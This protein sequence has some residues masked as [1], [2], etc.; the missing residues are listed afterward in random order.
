MNRFY[1]QQGHG[2][3][4]LNREFVEKNSEV[5]I[6]LS[7][8]NCK[9]EQIEKH[10]KE[11]H[12]RNA[13]VL[14][15]PQFY[16]PRTERENILN[17]PYWN[18][19]SFETVS[20]LQSGS[21]ELCSG[22]IRYQ[23][24]ELEVDEVILPGRYTNAVNEEWLE[25][26]YSIVNT[27]AS[28]NLDELVYTTLALGPDVIGQKQVFDRIVNEVIQ[29]PVDG[30]YIV[31]NTP[32]YLVND[33]IY[34]YNLLD[35]LLS[36]KLAGKKVLVGYANQQALIFA[37][38][39]VSGLATGNFRNVRKF[40]PETFDVPLEDKKPQRATWYYDGQTLSEYRIPAL[41][42]AYQRGLKGNF[43]PLSPYTKELLESSN[44]THIKWGEREAFRHYLTL[45]KQQW[46][47]VNKKP[48][49][50]RIQEVIKLLEEAEEKLNGLVE[51]AFRPGERS[52]IKCFEP[53]LNAITALNADRGYE[54][55]LLD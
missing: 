48:V 8:R 13:A 51:N 14:F 1:L 6:I 21:R 10:A 39:G 45:M 19:I 50:Q 40:N 12:K 17:Y 23:V 22:I 42:L 33:E 2:M 30:V 53:T 52:F 47:Q 20:F 38:V 29:Y 55:E 18:G 31:L 49:S 26:Q 41:A 4:A 34:I 37:G 35:G 36:L 46:E 5:G 28:M 27:A 9:R 54:L 16:Q 15:D 25:M 32:S 3:L 44:P 43:G 11:L 7:P 24:E